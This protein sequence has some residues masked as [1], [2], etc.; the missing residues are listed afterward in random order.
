MVSKLIGQLLP[1]MQAAFNQIGGI[2]ALEACVERQDQYL[3]QVFP[4][5]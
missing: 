2:E 4:I 1:A 5:G 3:E